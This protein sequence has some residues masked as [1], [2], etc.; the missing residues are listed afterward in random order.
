MVTGLHAGY[1]QFLLGALGNVAK[2][3]LDAHTQVG[4]ALHALALRTATAKDVPKTTEA[5]ETAK[6]VAE[7]AQDVVHRHASGI[8]A[9]AHLLTGKPEL[10]VAGTLVGSLRTL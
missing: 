3:H 4:T 8:F 9:A 10:V 5:T 1:L 6:Q 7:L 2:R